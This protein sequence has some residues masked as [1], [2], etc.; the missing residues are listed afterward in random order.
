MKKQ[1]EHLGKYGS[2]NL[3]STVMT[4]SALALRDAFYML[5]ISLSYKEAQAP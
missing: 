5:A 4:A 1:H 2:M 3:I